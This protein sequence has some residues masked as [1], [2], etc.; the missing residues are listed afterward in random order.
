MGEVACTPKELSTQQP[1]EPT[2]GHI[3]AKQHLIQHRVAVRGLAD[4]DGVARGQGRR[5][6]IAGVRLGGLS[7]GEEALVEEKLP[8]VRDGAARQSV[9][10]VFAVWAKMR[11]NNI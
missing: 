11:T 4:E 6:G 5:L 8:D 9:F 1:A 3:V 10:S 2:L 7:L